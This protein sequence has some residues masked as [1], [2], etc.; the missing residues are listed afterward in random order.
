MTTSSVTKFIIS[1][2]IVHDLSVGTVWL[3]YCQDF[4]SRFYGDMV[5]QIMP[6]HPDKGYAVFVKTLK[7]VVCLLLL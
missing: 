5:C 1:K 2:F 3:R 4:L 7:L 6:V